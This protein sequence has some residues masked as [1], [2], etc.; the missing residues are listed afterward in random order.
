MSCLS[1]EYHDDNYEYQHREDPNDP[2][3]TRRY[4]RPLPEGTNEDDGGVMMSTRD[5]FIFKEEVQYFQAPKQGDFDGATKALSDKDICMDLLA[6]FNDIYPMGFPTEQIICKLKNDV[7]AAFIKLKEDRKKAVE[8]M[9]RQMFEDGARMKIE[10]PPEIQR[11]PGMLEAQGFTHEEFF[12]M[13]SSNKKVNIPT[14]LRVTDRIYNQ[15]R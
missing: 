6:D 2:G 4:K 5:P 10:R 8:E 11:D 15:L 12:K 13:F 3:T 1:D 14:L 9:R 7:I